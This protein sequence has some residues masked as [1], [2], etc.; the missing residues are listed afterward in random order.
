MKLKVLGRYQNG[1]R[2]I[3]V[4]PGDEIEVKDE[5]AAWLMND[6]PGCFEDPTRPKEEPPDEQPTDEARRQAGAA[7]DEAQRL[8]EDAHTEAN[9]TRIAA[10][11]TGEPKPFDMPPDGTTLPIDP[12]PSVITGPDSGVEIVHRADEGEQ[13][14]VAEEQQATEADITFTPSAAFEEELNEEEEAQKG[15]DAPPHDKAVRRSPKQ[16]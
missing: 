4:Y 5:L 8:L 1:A 11:D 7:L 12:V 6:A 2:N 9:R 14:V 10:L 13:Q 3:D 16:K 15:L